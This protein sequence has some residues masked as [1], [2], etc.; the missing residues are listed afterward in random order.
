MH[1][2]HTFHKR[3]SLPQFAHSN[4]GA[5][6]RAPGVEGER[7]G[8]GEGFREGDGVRDG[9]KD[10]LRDVDGSGKAPNV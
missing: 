1:F 9:K 6:V 8:E 7:E 10:E 2:S 4:R 3:S 5:S